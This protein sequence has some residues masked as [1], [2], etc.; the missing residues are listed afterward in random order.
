MHIG[1]VPRFATLKVTMSV[2][3]SVSGRRVVPGHPAELSDSF[4]LLITDA[5][6]H[7]FE[8][9]LVLKSIYRTNDITVRGA[10]KIASNPTCSSN[11]FY[12]SVNK[13]GAQQLVLI[14]FPPS[15]R[16]LNFNVVFKIQPFLGWKSAIFWGVDLANL[17]PISSELW[18]NSKNASMAGKVLG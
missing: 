9:D 18:G 5:K 13:G 6:N 2:S 17:W 7:V 4:K 8:I 15:R 1:P 11:G 14:Q 12:H 3:L 10:V 16:F